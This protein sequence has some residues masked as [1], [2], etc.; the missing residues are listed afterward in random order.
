MSSPDTLLPFATIPMS[1][2]FVDGLNVHVAQETTG[3]EFGVTAVSLEGLTV[4]VRL[5][6]RIICTIVSVDHCSEAVTLPFTVAGNLYVSLTVYG[7][8]AVNETVQL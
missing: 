5:A 6:P 7:A 2:V 8:F 4:M 1:T 3:I